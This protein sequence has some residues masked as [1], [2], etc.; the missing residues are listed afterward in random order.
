MNQHFLI[1]DFL[2]AL[3]KIGLP[4]GKASAASSICITLPWKRGCS[5]VAGLVAM[6]SAGAGWD[7]ARE[8]EEEHEAC[9][10]MIGVS[11]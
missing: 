3:V 2:P 4:A 7:L 1:E 5:S 11:R 10:N 8:K 9:G 6:S